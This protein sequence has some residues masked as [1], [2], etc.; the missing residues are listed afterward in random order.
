ML[1]PGPPPPRFC[2]VLPAH[3]EAAHIDAVVRGVRRQ[4]FEA[5]VVDDGSTDDTAR[6][7][8]EAG[9]VVLRQSPNQGKG[10]ALTRGFSHAMERGYDGVVTMDADGQHDPASMNEFVDAYRRTGIPVLVG[11]RMSRPGPMPWHRRLTNRF[12]SWMICRHMRQFLPDTQNG[13]RL[14]HASV[15]PLLRTESGG[16]AAESEVLLRL[17]EHAIRMDWVPVQAIYGTEESS[18][19]PVRD[20]LRFLR[21]MLRFLVRR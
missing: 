20:T 7:A 8:R 21:M 9:A 10:A 4:G 18:I 6:V 5:V 13:F 16:F 1:N 3:N 15:L 17:D 12:M 14:Y 19:R 2:A 11:N